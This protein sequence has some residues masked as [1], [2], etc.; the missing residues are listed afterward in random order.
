MKPSPLSPRDRRLLRQ[1]LEWQALHVDNAL[2]AARQKRT[3]AKGQYGTDEHTAY[4]TAAKGFLGWLIP[5]VDYTVPFCLSD[6]ERYEVEFFGEA[7]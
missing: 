7:A 6:G 5:R 2:E 1:W 3:V 4:W